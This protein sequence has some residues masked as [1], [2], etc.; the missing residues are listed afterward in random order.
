MIHMA[1]GHFLAHECFGN[2]AR[3]FAASAQ[4]SIRHNPHQADIAS[5]VDQLDLACRQQTTQMV[6]FFTILGMMTRI[7][8]TENANS[9]HEEVKNRRV[10]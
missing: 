4:A 8:A 9:F 3:D 6:G 7:G 2:H 10:E 5:P 1:S